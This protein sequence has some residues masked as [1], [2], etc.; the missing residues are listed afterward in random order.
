M[1]E[2]WF[3]KRTLLT[4]WTVRKTKKKPV[5]EQIK[6][7]FSMEAKMMELRLSYFG[8]TSL[9]HKTYWERQKC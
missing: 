8:G 9:E 5:L 2:I 7:E 6:A 4:P 3:W 1:F